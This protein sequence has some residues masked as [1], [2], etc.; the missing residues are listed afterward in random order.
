MSYTD[1]FNIWPFLVMSSNKATNKADK[2][3]RY[4]LKIS[5]QCAAGLKDHKLSP[6]I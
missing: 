4:H 1:S 5:S 6:Y 3:I 2:H